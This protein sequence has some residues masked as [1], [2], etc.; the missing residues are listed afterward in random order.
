MTCSPD[1]PPMPTDFTMPST[2]MTAEAGEAGTW[3]L[4]PTSDPVSW[5]RALAG[6]PHAFG[7]TWESCRAMELTT[8][9]ETHLVEFRAGSARAVCPI[10]RRPVGETIDLATPLGYSGF[11]GV[12]ECSDF[13]E[14]WRRFA[15][16]LG[17]VTS[18]LTLNPLLDQRAWFEPADR[19][20]HQVLYVLD[21]RADE[22]EIFAGMSR[23]RQRQLRAGP[24]D[25]VRVVD[26]EPRV[27]EFFARHFAAVMEARNASAIYRLTPDALATLFASD[28][29]FV[30]GVESQGELEAATMFAHTP[31]VG[32]SFLNVSL[33]EGRRH[34]TI[35]TWHALLRLKRLGV[36]Y[37]NLGGGMRLGD[38]IAKFKERFGARPVSLCALKQV[39]DPAAYEA[40]CRAAGADA[41][42]RSGY[43]PAYRAS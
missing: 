34:A 6:L 23:N 37:L 3:R 20:C 38:G 39:H 18:F 9:Y 22:A 25:G 30:V 24:P 17:A 32:D 31:W 14:Q 12:G 15:R 29:T 26:D 7:H 35:I 41:A 11:V 2:T 16:S 1:P 21:L 5:Q 28:G 42:D 4:V 36:P 33:P 43:F 19:Y 8:G 13:P 40:L 27:R 10:A